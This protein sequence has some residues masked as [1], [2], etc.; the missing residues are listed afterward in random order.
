MTKG[1][2]LK[3]FPAR[4]TCRKCKYAFAGK[5]LSLTENN[6]TMRFNN[7]GEHPLDAISVD[8]CWLQQQ[9]ACDFLVLDWQ[10]HPYLVELKGG[11]IQRAL[12]QLEETLR[13]LMPTHIREPIS[14]FL[15]A[16]DVSIPRTKIQNREKTMRGTWPYVEIIPKSRQHTHC[17]AP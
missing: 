8:D 12:D 11:N 10:G 6:K 16:K 5:I 15:I 4:H 13:T 17:L 14:C 1:D 3:P 2:F 9:T 7:P